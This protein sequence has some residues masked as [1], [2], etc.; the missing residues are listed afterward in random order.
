MRPEGEET[1]IDFLPLLVASHK[2]ITVKPNEEG[3]EED[4]YENLL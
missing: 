4:N 2:T 3:D 1:H